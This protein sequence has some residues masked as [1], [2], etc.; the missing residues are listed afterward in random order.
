ML[1]CYQR[2]GI[3]AVP[4]RTRSG[5]RQYPEE[6]VRIVSFVKRA[7]ELGFTLKEAKELL[8]LRSAP[9]ENRLSVRAA[10]KAKI[11]DV[12]ARV[13]DLIAIRDALAALV[14]ECQRSRKTVRCPILD[15]L[16]NRSHG[17]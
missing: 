11:S 15:A 8:K 13:R 17:P 2:E 4:A 10:A 14:T 6:T 12:D 5:Y 1:R 7:Q 3:I 9:K 16:E